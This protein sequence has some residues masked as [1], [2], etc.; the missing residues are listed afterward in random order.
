[1]VP[2]PP[3][4]QLESSDTSF[5]GHPRG[6]STLFLTELWERFSYY[7]MRALLIL[8]MTA[9]SSQGGLGFDVAKAAAIYGLYTAAVYLSALPGGWLADRLF[10]L[11]RAVLY[12]GILIALGHYSLA[13]G[14]LSFFYAGLILIVLGTGLLKPNV[15]VLV[16]QLYMPKDIRRD[17]GFSIFYMG[18]NLGAFISPLACGYLGQR[19]GWHLGFGLAA[20]GMTVGL[21]QF[22]LGAK[23]L[24]SGD[25]GPKASK[26]REAQGQLLRGGGWCAAVVLG[27]IYLAHSGVVA[28]TAERLSTLMGV[29]LSGFQPASLSGS[30]PLRRGLPPSGVA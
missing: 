5:F 11:Q 25:A 3:T 23:H 28:I 4:E 20:A 14:T 1:M 7:G 19:V 6:L 13:L 15:S 22:L 16:G 21:T 30:P 29:V 24:R 2:Q 26:K 27:L 9:K 8:Y 18:I 12:G 10:G 17:A